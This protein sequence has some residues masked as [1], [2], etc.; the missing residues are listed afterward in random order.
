MVEDEYVVETDSFPMKAK[1]SMLMRESVYQRKRPHKRSREP[2]RS[3][4]GIGHDHLSAFNDVPKRAASNPIVEDPR[5]SSY[6]APMAQLSNSF[7]PRQYDVLYYP[8]RQKTH[9]D[10]YPARQQTVPEPPSPRHVSFDL[11]AKPQHTLTSR[12]SKF[13]GIADSP[14]LGSRGGSSDNSRLFKVKRPSFSKRR[15][16]V[17]QLLKDG[18]HG[19]KGLIGNIRKSVLSEE[20]G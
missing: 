11:D 3:A 19:V 18:K 4:T 9:S 2:R 5:E 15:P 17:E 12:T 10:P 13:F 20:N 14:K 1:R 16:S 6:A 8:A 7:P